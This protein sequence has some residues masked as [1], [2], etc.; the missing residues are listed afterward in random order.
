MQGQAEAF[1]SHAALHIRG[2]CLH[3]R[4]YDSFSLALPFVPFPR[5]TPASPKS[6]AGAPAE[7]SI[8]TA[9]PRPGSN[10]QSRARDSASARLKGSEKRVTVA[11]YLLDRRSMRRIE[12]TSRITARKHATEFRWTPAANLAAGPR[13]YRRFNMH[14]LNDSD[15]ATNPVT[16][17]E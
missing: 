9:T 10:V 12:S 3:C 7:L 14:E 8:T 1:T 2:V 13:G 6:T 4:W 17:V 11:H 16:G 15:R 5:R